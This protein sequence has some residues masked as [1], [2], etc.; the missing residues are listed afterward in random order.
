MLTSHPSVHVYL[1]AIQ[2]LRMPLLNHTIAQVGVP[3][4]KDCTDLEPTFWCSPPSPH[5]MSALF[6]VLGFGVLNIARAA[7]PQT[8]GCQHCLASVLAAYIIDKSYCNLSYRV[9]VG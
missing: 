5:V 3:V 9:E 8:L 1:P 7:L 4:S 2:I 6:Y